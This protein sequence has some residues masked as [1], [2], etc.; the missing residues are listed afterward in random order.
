MHARI[1]VAV[2][3]LSLA[4]CGDFE[5]LEPEPDDVQLG[6]APV[7]EGVDEDPLVVMSRNLYL[8]ADIDGLL[9]PNADLETVIARALEEIV[10]TDFSTRAAALAREIHSARPHAIG[11]Q[12]VTSYTVHLA[13]GTVVPVPALNLPLD[14]LTTLQ[15]ELAA[16]GESYDVA[17][18]LDN[19][20]ISLPFAELE[21]GVPLFIRYQD[22]EAILVRSGIQFSDAGG[23]HFE[24]QQMLSIGGDEFRNL[25]GWVWADIVVDGT[26]YRFASTH[27]EIQPFRSVQELQ[28]AELAR[29]LASVDGPLVLMGD[30]NSAANHDAPPESRTAS[31]RILRRSGLADLVLRQR[32]SADNLTCCH[33]TDLS[34]PTP[35]LDQRLDL[36]LARTGPAG[37]GGR[38]RIEVIGDVES[39]IFVHPLG[40]TL[41]PSDHAGVVAEIWTAPGRR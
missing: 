18:R 4:A 29:S 12:E 25:R 30:F 11:L 21:P 23:Q 34:N 39:D 14:F 15:D 27:L 31:Y 19:V 5:P 3:L 22:G 38:S 36:I 16:L 10:R 7:P 2:V 13:D 32:H 26:Q 17:V 1:L 6:S 24:N 20:S 33:A 28:A 9:D 35:D 40:Y 37:F 8:G 41:W